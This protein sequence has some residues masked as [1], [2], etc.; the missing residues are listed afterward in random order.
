MP[1]PNRGYR[2]GRLA[3]P[4][5]P[6]AEA[7]CAEGEEK[8]RGKKKGNLGLDILLAKT[9]RTDIGEHMI[10]HQRGCESGAHVEELSE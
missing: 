9:R 10:I 7:V 8:E 6:E 1:A 2:Q 4:R 5:V 3:V